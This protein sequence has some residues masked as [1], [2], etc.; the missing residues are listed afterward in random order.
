M[1]YLP[2]EE[3]INDVFTLPLNKIRKRGCIV[4]EGLMNKA[5]FSGMDGEYQTTST[6]G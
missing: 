5:H 3:W 2:F 6:I 4:W 1:A